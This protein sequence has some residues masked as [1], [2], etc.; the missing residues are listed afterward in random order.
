VAD[1]ILVIEDNPPGLLALSEALRIKLPG[2]LVDTAGSAESGLA[3]LASDQYECV[4]CDVLMPG[5][6]GIEL[7]AFVRQH[8]P[9]LSV[10]MVTAGEFVREA[11]A[12]SKGAFAFLPKPLDLDLLLRTVRE[13]VERTKEIRAFR[14][15]NVR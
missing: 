11:E 12:L 1:R 8:Q 10:V 13:A 14:K 5:L 6:D 7:L 9:E 4:I 15:R 2:M 3:Q